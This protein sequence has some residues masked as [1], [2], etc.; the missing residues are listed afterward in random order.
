MGDTNKEWP[1][2]IPIGALA[3]R[4]LAAKIDDPRWVEDPPGSNQGPVVRWA[5]ERWL[6]RGDFEREYARGRLAWCAGAVC[7]ALVEA[8]SEE[9]KTV[10][11][12]SCARLWRKLVTL[13]RLVPKGQEQ[14]GD[15]YFL[16]DPPHHVGLVE[17]ILEDRLTTVSGNS[18]QPR[19]KIADRVSRHTVSRAQVFGFARI[20]Q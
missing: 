18:N 15:L 6:T 2:E 5:C 7:S 13:G 14:V 17:A 12:L 16:G 3:L 4:V 19:R 8:G 11:S 1:P 20:L 10:A 9:I